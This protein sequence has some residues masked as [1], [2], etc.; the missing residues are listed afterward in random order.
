MKRTIGQTQKKELNRQVV[1]GTQVSS[2]QKNHLIKIGTST[3]GRSRIEQLHSNDQQS[4]LI[5]RTM[6]DT[7]EKEEATSTNE[8]FSNTLIAQ[9]A[10][11]T[12]PG[13]KCKKVKKNIFQHQEYDVDKILK[14]KQER[15]QKE[16]TEISTAIKEAEQ[17]ISQNPNKKDDIVKDLFQKARGF[18][19]VRLAKKIALEFLYTQAPND[20]KIFEEL[21]AV[22]ETQSPKEAREFYVK[23]LSN[24]N[25]VTIAVMH[26]RFIIKRHEDSLATSALKDLFDNTKPF[27]LNA[28][29]IL[30]DQIKQQLKNQSDPIHKHL[31]AFVEADLRGRIYS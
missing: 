31:K 6:E 20:K 4:T 21:G 28:E 11:D 10:D 2:L 14:L 22:L 1:T 23:G 30:A 18:T 7:K 16:I 12:I 25:L 9:I 19:N 8:P 26:I 3:N 27:S 17:N 24:D 5:G 13:S 29:A 15:E